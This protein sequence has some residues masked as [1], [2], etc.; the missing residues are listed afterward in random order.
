MIIKRSFPVPVPA[1]IIPHTLYLGP[2]HRALIDDGGLVRLQTIDLPPN[3][4]QLSPVPFQA[5]AVSVSS[6]L[7]RFSYSLL[8]D[9]QICDHLFY[10]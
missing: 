9:D 4:I 7:K 10:A 5:T 8:V 1:E 2:K 3:G 6:L